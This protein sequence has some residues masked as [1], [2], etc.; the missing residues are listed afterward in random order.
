[1]APPRSAKIISVIVWL[2]WGL[3]RYPYAL[4]EVVL[5][6]S[7]C[8]GAETPQD[9]VVVHVVYWV[10]DGPVLEQTVLKIY[11]CDGGNKCDC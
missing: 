3:D 10:M 7:P 8:R 6:L 2:L 1:M 9:N 4:S 5:I 11:G